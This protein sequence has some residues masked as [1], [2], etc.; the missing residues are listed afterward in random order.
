MTPPRLTVDNIIG[1]R[2]GPNARLRVYRMGRPVFITATFT[3]TFPWATGLLCHGARLWAVS[4]RR[5]G[6]ERQVEIVS[7]D[8]A[9]DVDL[10]VRWPTAATV[11]LSVEG[12]PLRIS[13]LSDS[14]LLVEAAHAWS[15]EGR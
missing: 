6:V 10:K 4:E 7:A 14:A 12:Q 8:R 13:S 11:T 5:F 1:A 9:I 2:L 3:G 15:S